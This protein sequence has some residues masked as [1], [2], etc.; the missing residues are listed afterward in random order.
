MKH[1]VSVQVGLQLCLGR[2]RTRI[3]ASVLEQCS[4]TDFLGKGI[5]LAGASCIREIRTSSRE[6]AGRNK[7][8]LALG[9]AVGSSVQMAL[10]VTP[11]TVIF[12]WSAGVVQSRNRRL[13]SWEC[14]GHFGR[15]DG[16]YTYAFWCSSGVLHTSRRDVCFLCL[17]VR[18][19]TRTLRPPLS[20]L[21]SLR[22]GREV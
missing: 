2:P 5:A 8:D 18:A 11:A 17:P 19:L 4:L 21:S 3:G 7:M 15:L 6:V 13:H 10:F 14:V 1:S 12:G 9:V 20:S 22:G 16:V